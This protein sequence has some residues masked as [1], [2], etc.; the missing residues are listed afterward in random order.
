MVAGAAAERELCSAVAVA[1]GP[2]ERARETC[3]MRV[4]GA[5]VVADAGP[6]TN[7]AEQPG[8]RERRCTVD[9]FEEDAHAG[10]QQEPH[11]DGSTQH[12]VEDPD[13]DCEHYHGRPESISCRCD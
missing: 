1:V 8:C 7:S 13:T 6:S 11:R 12:D 3:A 5:V 10:Q 4:R 9:A 2:V